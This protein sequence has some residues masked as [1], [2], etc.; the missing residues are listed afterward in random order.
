MDTEVGRHGNGAG[1]MERRRVGAVNMVKEV[2]RHG[3]KGADEGD[4]EKQW[5]RRHDTGRL[6]DMKTGHGAGDMEVKGTDNM[7]GEVGRH[8]N[9]GGRGQH[10]KGAVNTEEEVRRHGKG[11]GE[12]DMERGQTT[13][14]GRLRDMETGQVR[15]TWK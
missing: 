7:E 13:W 8:G 15:A 5:G 12:G 2:G 6:G 9:G 4:M 3:K 11:A 1:D 14:T 10:R